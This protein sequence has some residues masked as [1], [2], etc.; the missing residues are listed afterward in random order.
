M[1][2]GRRY[3][4]ELFR[5]K[6]LAH[7][8]AE[9]VPAL[10]P[11]LG[12]A[13]KDPD[14]ERLLDSGAYQNGMLGSLLRND[15]PELVRA[16]AGL[17]LPHYLRPFPAS[18]II[19][20]KSNTSREHAVAIPAGTQLASTPVDGTSCRFMTSS[21]LEIHPLEIRERA[22]EQASGGIQLTVELQG[23]SL[24]AWR[25]ASLRLF[26]AGDRASAAEMLQLLSRKL[27][28][29]VIVP[30]DGGSCMVLP[31]ECLKPLGFAQGESLLPYPSHAF[32]GYRLL[33]EY[34]NVP[35]KFFFFDITG[36]E[37][38]E[39]RG[40]GRQ[41]TITFDIDGRAAVE[42]LVG[43]VAFVPNAVPA[44]NLYSCTAAP[45]YVNHRARRYLVRPCGPNPSHR[46]VFSVDRVTGY[47]L[48]SGQERTYVAFELFG[49]D[50]AS[51]PVYH[52]GLE[53][54]RFGDGYE[55]YLSV[56][57]PEGSGFIAGE[58]LS[59]DLTCTTGTL[60]ESLRI[61]DISIAEASL[62]PDVTFS[63]ITPVNP[64]VPPPLGPGLLQRLVTHLYLNQVSLSDAGH[65]QA[66]LRLYLQQG[67]APDGPQAA[68]LKRIEGMNDVKIKQAESMVAGV[69]LRGSTIGLKVRQDHFAGPGDLYLFGCVLDRF[70]AEYASINSFTRLTADELL[71]G[72]SRRWPLRQE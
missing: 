46:Q 13:G 17:I 66:L 51:G 30:A 54:S 16:L 36:W 55:A 8:F 7:E 10:A 48:R 24:A 57:F 14:V 56:G 29:I 47:S 1:M 22:V 39:H 4:T 34:F 32:P 26:L 69:P 43:R 70:F 18:T 42:H 15:F 61:G 27:N 21:N 3:R 28:R 45:V 31:A 58:T 50:T 12:E 53:K 72:E 19:R 63:N 11:F 44:V 68:N 9:A 37:G 38:W 5:L 59:I 41:F 49:S 2:Q 23:N 71:G 20:F 40:A 67:S 60:P 33:Q 6:E 62:P 65:L 35:E 25:P 64:G 52:A